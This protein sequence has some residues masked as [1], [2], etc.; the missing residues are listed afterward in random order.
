MTEIP[1]HLGG[2]RV[3]IYPDGSFGVP[4]KP[5]DASIQHLD[6][7]FVR[8]DDFRWKYPIAGRKLYKELKSLIDGREMTLVGKGPS[9]DNLSVADFPD[10]TSV[11]LAINDSIH[12][13]AKLKLPNPVFAIQQDAALRGRCKPE[14]GG[15]IVSSHAA[16]YYEDFEPK[17]IYAPYHLDS[18][19][20]TLTV[21]VG[22]RIGLELGA[23]RFR[24]IA[25]D[26]CVTRDCGYAKV[27]GYSPEAG[28]QSALRFLG[29][30]QLI[31]NAL[32]SAPHRWV[33]P[34]RPTVE[35]PETVPTP[36]PDT[37]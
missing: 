5:D 13:V 34:A 11:V 20:N 14:Q 1:K 9:L 4:R 28:K 6:T 3:R 24:L 36:A 16:S 30:R 29:H 27:I 8:V 15:I 23:T 10:P 12:T 18:S 19:P 17:Y 26:S 35:S 7:L 31:Q 21:V 2:Q 32:K 22:I 33:L 37:Q 25:F